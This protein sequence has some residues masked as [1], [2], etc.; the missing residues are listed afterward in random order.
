MGQM[1]PVSKCFLLKTES[2]SL[3]KGGTLKAFEDYLGLFAGTAYQR[4]IHIFNYGL[5]I[6]VAP[7]N[8][9]R[10]I[11]LPNLLQMKA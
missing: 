11:L 10:R 9:L 8:L 1:F 7:F 4:V 6:L 3:S 5:R 2:M